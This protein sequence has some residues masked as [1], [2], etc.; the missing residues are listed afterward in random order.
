MSKAAAKKIK[1]ILFDVDGVLTDGT[2]WFVPGASASAE[3]T[4]VRREHLA[5]AGG[6]G[7]NSDDY[8]ETKGFNAHDGTGITLARM[9]GLKTGVVTKRISEVVKLRARDLKLDFVV[10][11]CADKA[12]AIDDIAREAGVKASEIAYVGD[13]IIDL[14]AMRKCGLAIAVASAREEVKDEAHVVTDHTG[15][16][17]AARDAIEYVLRAQ[18]KWEGVMKQYIGR[19]P[20]K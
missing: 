3:E 17:G 10:Q 15:G 11:G 14:P 18:G 1:V 12:T 13:D 8:A 19:K 5:D 7:I 2:I 6:Y 9:G 16:D 4:R 20:A